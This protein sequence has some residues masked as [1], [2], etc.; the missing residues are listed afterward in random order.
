MQNES[1]GTRVAHLSSA[2]PWDDTR[3]FGRL[4][5]SL[6]RHGYEVTFVV[7][8]A[9]APP[10]HEGVRIAVAPVDDI[11]DSPEETLDFVIED[12]DPGEHRVAIKAADENN[13]TTYATRAVTIGP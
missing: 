12:L 5:R 10:D 2:H 13:N 8:D 9:D 6:A 3:I 4:C 11:F 7:A 1:S